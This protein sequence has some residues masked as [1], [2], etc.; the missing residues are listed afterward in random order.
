LR[1]KVESGSCSGFVDGSASCCMLCSRGHQCG[2]VGMYFLTIHK[3]MQH[4]CSACVHS[5]M[6]A[7]CLLLWNPVTHWPHFAVA[8]SLATLSHCL[9][10]GGVWTLK[11]PGY[12]GGLASDV[13]HML[14]ELDTHLC[15]P[16]CHS[17]APTE[18]QIYTI[19]VIQF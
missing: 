18:C 4:Y 6:P 7:T 16:H 2:G 12:M 1:V 11:Y 13:H 3:H 14:I 5:L 9:L 15:H 17:S 19:L 8:T 10:G